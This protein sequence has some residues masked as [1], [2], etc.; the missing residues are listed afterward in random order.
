MPKQS[1]QQ[2]TNALAECITERLSAD[3]SV[4]I[5]FTCTPTNKKDTVDFWIAPRESVHGNDGLEAFRKK[6]EAIVGIP[7][8]DELRCNQLF[9]FVQ[10]DDA[11]YPTLVYSVDTKSGN[12]KA[13]VIVFPSEEHAEG[14][15]RLADLP[16][17]GKA[18]GM[19]FHTP[20][21]IPVSLRPEGVKA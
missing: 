14:F 15:R 5:N 20:G 8:Q 11:G 21:N 2:T 3:P 19:E 18:N 17:L 4:K 6:V 7:I 13:R 12:R 1:T 10:Y 9:G 16:V